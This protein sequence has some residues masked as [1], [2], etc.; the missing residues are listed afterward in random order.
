[1]S[2][3]PDSYP[4]HNTLSQPFSNLQS[5]HV[6]PIYE[7]FGQN[8]RVNYVKDNYKRSCTIKEVHRDDA[9]NWYYTVYFDNGDEKQTIEKYLENIQPSGSRKKKNSKKNM[10]RQPLMEPIRNPTRN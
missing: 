3:H 1:M 2:E 4:W 5:D 6:V 9:P 7:R 8:Q 10:A